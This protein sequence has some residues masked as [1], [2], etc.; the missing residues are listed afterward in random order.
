MSAEGVHKIRVIFESG[1]QLFGKHKEPSFSVQKQLFW[2]VWYE[3]GNFKTMDE[4]EK[5]VST[6]SERKE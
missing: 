3:I 2:F 4:V 1:F 5:Y 6:L